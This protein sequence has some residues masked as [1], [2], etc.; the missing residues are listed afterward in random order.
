MLD[1]YKDS[2]EARF[3]SIDHRFSQFSASSASPVSISNVS[4]Q[5]AANLIGVPVC[6]IQTAWDLS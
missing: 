6:C 2:F 4:C 3:A 5:D 1:S